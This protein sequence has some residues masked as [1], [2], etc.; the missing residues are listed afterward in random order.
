M[1]YILKIGSYPA[2]SRKRRKFG[3]FPASACFLS[4][5][6]QIIPSDQ[7]LSNKEFKTVFLNSYSEHFIFL[8]NSSNKSN[9]FF[10]LLIMRLP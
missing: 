9:K 10:N 7:I 8:L 2:G 4:G 6:N 5:K 1:K 3:N